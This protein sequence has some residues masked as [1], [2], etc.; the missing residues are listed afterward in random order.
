MDT[1][2]LDGVKIAAGMDSTH[3][4]G[5]RTYKASFVSGAAATSEHAVSNLLLPGNDNS[6][7]VAKEFKGQINFAEVITLP[8]LNPVAAPR[9]PIEQPD[10]LNF[11]LVPYGGEPPVHVADR[12]VSN[13]GRSSTLATLPFLTPSPP[14][15]PVAP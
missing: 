7:C 3:K 2:K 6:L 14:R 12:C 11:V 13:C 4:V 15:I 1:S 5:K 10:G 9:P 8:T